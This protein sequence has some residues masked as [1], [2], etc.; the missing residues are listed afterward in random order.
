MSVIYQ[1]LYPDAAFYQAR[2]LFD[3]SAA[4]RISV[5]NAWENRS[6][7]IEAGEDVEKVRNMFS[8]AAYMDK[9]IKDDG[10]GQYILEWYDENG[11]L[12]CESS[13]YSDYGVAYEGAIYLIVSEDGIDTHYLHNLEK[14]ILQLPDPTPVPTA[15]PNPSA[16]AS[17]APTK[18]P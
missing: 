18:S 9:G 17:P 7:E 11:S 15:P 12:L 4:A 1:L 16:S 10:Y 2:E 14:E 13:V 5:R 3:L 6:F 8:E